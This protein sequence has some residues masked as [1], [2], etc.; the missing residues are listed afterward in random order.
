MS[1]YKKTKRA[2]S[3]TL[4]LAMLSSCATTYH[5]DG[6]I[7]SKQKIGKKNH[8]QAGKKA[9]TKGAIVGGAAAGSFIG[10]T[11]IMEGVGV[12][13]TLTS[14]AIFGAAGAL[15]VGLPVAATVA[16]TSYLVNKK[17]N[18]DVY[19]F[20]VKSLKDNKTFVVEQYAIPMP[21]NTKVQIIERNKSVFIKR[22]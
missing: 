18:K 10:W 17:N 4:I 7:T 16:T 13:S 3:L 6:V 22:K 20:N 11:G 14:V 2:A 8:L 5:G 21:V 19:R 1:F 15:T 9:G 12:G